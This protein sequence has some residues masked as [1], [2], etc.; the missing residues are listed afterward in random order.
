MKYLTLAFH[1]SSLKFS[2]ACLYVSA[3]KNVFIVEN[4]ENFNK[5]PPIAKICS[6]SYHPEKMTINILVCVL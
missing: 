4:L 2:I 5:D 3:L 6:Y 1:E